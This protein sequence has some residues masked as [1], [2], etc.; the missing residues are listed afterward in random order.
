MS[1]RAL[2]VHFLKLAE[3]AQRDAH[4][5]KNRVTE[6]AS[7]DMKIKWTANPSFYD[8]R[9]FDHE[10]AQRVSSALATDPLWKA[11]VADHQWFMAKSQMYGLE[12]QNQLLER[13]IG[14]M[15][16]VPSD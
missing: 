6:V 11:H 7:R 4:K 2:Q 14:M 13:M 16:L 1:T 9:T 15:V 3:E 12:A 8:K 10:L 5:R